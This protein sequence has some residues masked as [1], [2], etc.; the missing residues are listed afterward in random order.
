ML[1]YFDSMSMKTSKLI[2]M[3][4]AEQ[5]IQLPYFDNYGVDGVF[6]TE[7]DFADFS[8]VQRTNVYHF[9]G[10]DDYLC[11][12]DQAQYLADSIPTFKE[13][14]TYTCPGTGH[15]WFGGRGLGQKGF[16][17]DQVK[18]LGIEEEEWVEPVKEESGA[19]SLTAAISALVVVGIA[20]F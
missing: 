12:P 13:T 4:Q 20:L 6:P 8:G 18:V 9:V 15:E 19:K 10:A 7:S 17:S 5:N 16:I 11:T 1:A 2:A 14:Y 3:N